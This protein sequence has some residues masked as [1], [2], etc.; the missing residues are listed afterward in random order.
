VKS[1]EAFTQFEMFA[2]LQKTR[3]HVIPAEA[4]I[5]ETIENTGFP[6]SRE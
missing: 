1:E 5:Q 6:P 2:Q 4:G 3:N